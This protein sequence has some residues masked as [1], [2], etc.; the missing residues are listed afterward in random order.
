LKEKKANTRLKKIRKI[1]LRT[2]LVLLLLILVS[3]I[4]LSLPVVQTKI[5]H[6]VTEKLNKSYGTDI[7][8]EEVEITIFG[9][10]QMK[11]VLVKDDRK[12]TLIFAKRIN[13]SILDTK[14]LLDGNL[15]FGA[16]TAN[17]LTLNVKT[18][19]GEKDTNLDKF[20]AAFD[21]GKPA[22]GKFLMTSNKM[23]LKNCRFREIDYN[24]EVPLDVDFTKLNAVLTDFKIK[25][26]NVY[27]N[28]DEM[29]FMDHRGLFI[30]DLKSKFTYTKKNIKLEKTTLK[31]KE[32]AFVGDVIL[33]YERKDFADFNNKVVFDVKTD[34]ASISSNDIRYFYKGLGK[35]K[36]FSL[37]GKIGGTLNDLTAKNL[38]L[39]DN[40]N[41]QINGDVNFKNLFAKKGQGEFYMKGSF[42]K[43]SSSYENLT[44][45][46]PDVLG[47]KL[48]SSLKKLGQ[49]NLKG[50]AEITTKSIDADFSLQTK[51]G[52]IAS[53]L[54]MTDIDTIDNATYK[55]NIVLDNFDVGSFLNRNDVGKVTMD[56]DVDG[57]GFV[58]KYI[59]TKFSGEVKSIAYNGYTYKNILADGSFKKPIF[60]GKINVNDPNLFFDFD[61]IVDLS[62]R[63]NIY[64]FHAKVDYAN[65]KKLNFM[66]DAVSVFKG[67]VVMKISGSTINTMKGDVVI[68]NASYQNTKDIY[69]FDNLT[70]NS[71]F[72]ANNEHT[73]SL[74]SPNQLNGKVQGK[75]EFN[76]IQKMVQNSL[77]SLYTNYKPN[78]LKK[79]QYLK[80]NFSEFNEVI[81]ILN[82]KV[83]LSSDAVLSGIIK[84][85]DNDFKLNFASKTIDAF[86]VHLDNIQLEVDNKNPLYNTYVQLDS[87]KTKYYKA[88]DFSLINATSKDTLSF[89]T[90]FK[91]GEKGTDFYNLNLYHTIDKNNQNIIGFNKSEMMFKDF[92]WYVNEN[93][94]DKNKI[95]FDKD[96]KN[97]SFDDIVVSHENQSIQLSGLVN[98][99]TNK[100]LQLTFQNVNLE[101]V[102]P[103]IKQFKFGGNLNGEVFLKQNN[104]I[105]QPTATLEIKDLVLND[106]SLGDLNL[107]ING[108][109]D[110]SKFTIDSKIENEN[111]KSFAANGNLEIVNDATLIDL[112]LN[113]QKFNLGVL[114]NLGGE[115]LSNIRGF[116]SGNAQL[117]GNV[118][119]IIYTGR[120]FV[121]EA[122]VTIPYLNVD[123]KIK[124]HSVVDVTQNK[125]IIQKTK[126]YD[127]KFNTEGNIQ[128]F[129]KHKQ[130]GDWELDLAIDSD[131]ILA[132][133]TKDH[134]DVA[135]FGT[136]FIDG[137]ATIKGPTNGL[138]INVNAKSEKG[139]DVKI[140]INDAEAVSENNY[141][142]FLTKEE[143][144]GT[145]NKNSEFVRN[146]NGLQMNF[147]FEINT[148]A[149]IEVILNRESGHGMRGKGVGIL[150][151][152]INTLGKFEMYGDFTVWEGSYNFKYGGLIDKKF[153]VKKYGSIVWSG[154]PYNATLNLEAVSK[155]I[156]ANPS[157]LI[158]NASFNKK[159]PVEVTIGLKGTITN[160]EPDFNINFPNV[161]SVLKSEIETKLSDKDTRQTQAIYLLSTGGFLS[162]EGLSQSQYTNFAFEK[163]TSLFHD[164]FND[165]N[166][167]VNVDLTYTAADKTAL[168]PTDGRVV[169]L[170][171]TQ[172]NE[173]ITINGKVGVP[174]GGVS[175]TTIVGNFEAQYRVNDDGTLNLRIFNKENDINYIGQGIG[176]TQ[177]AGVSYEVD[178]DTFKELINKIFK[179][180]VIE[181]EKVEVS[182]PEKPKIFPEGID[183]KKDKKKSV[184]KINNNSDAKK[185][186]DN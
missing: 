123:Y 22:S 162:Q 48:P 182:E 102:T 12:D 23:T 58:E 77:G 149:S 90:E 160:P 115:V 65:L 124:E 145:K 20:V 38:K 70:V 158:D 73:I 8:V 98:N 135:Y 57:K 49:F 28:I 170:I 120:L 6:Y 177:G 10:V 143:K 126:V 35:N 100:D 14:K 79:G 99:K 118:N 168:R 105:Y 94:N 63:E 178:F 132:L 141:I 69:F 60:K 91:G 96:L 104:A 4:A 13:T 55:G 53:K 17:D 176:Y 40:K 110:F 157:V 119:D 95:I 111:L 167:K 151:M 89:R 128:G 129:I 146:Y 46:L 161:S 175:E 109:D 64:D 125:F 140:P 113:F 11:K 159:I 139:T 93:N 26:P 16:M 36:T 59:D 85:D 24:R 18:Y 130:F 43:V 181:K 174:T 127:S 29:S 54:L 179:K 33:K 163:A 92:L 112:N 133:N 9:S 44:S 52:N 153:D 171:S 106:N 172:I 75:F 152:N 83:S 72:D 78:V 101:K 7:N 180:K 108:N 41:S 87:I 137:S 131:R 164:L 27:T 68:T 19:K 86:D 67:D 154:N 81:E 169:A 42:D 3:G 148:K 121:D 2:F 103:D 147:E 165:S 25:G 156:T 45:L 97:F 31:T 80:F 173:R 138:E 186:D 134:E 32:S 61:G 116:V 185:P 56:V 62:K 144:N 82:P 34:S 15:I 107:D 114:G 155:N 21:D 150:N 1:V 5:A 50:D 37:S 136:A 184:E 74:Y 166:S 183:M 47:K 30:E 88:R 71:S 84:G 117:N 66:T 51:L 39:I 142:H 76:Q 122:G